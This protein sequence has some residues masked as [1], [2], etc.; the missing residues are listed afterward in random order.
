MSRKH[1]VGMSGGVD[2]TVAALCLLEQGHPVEGLFM[3]N[4]EEDEDGY[5]TT[6]QDFQDARK[7]CER[8]GITLH[9]VSFAREYRDAVFAHFLA[10]YAAGRTPN[11]DVLCNREIKF[12]ACLDYARRLGAEVFATGHYARIGSG[13]SLLRAKDRAKDQT[14]FLHAVS[15]ADFQSTVFPIGELQK[16]EVRE[17]ARRHGLAT[18]DKKDST[19]ICFIGERPFR[20]FLEQYLPAR[21]GIIEDL[22]GRRVGEHRG[23]MYYTLGQRSG[24]GIG[25]RKNADDAPWFVVGKLMEKNVLQVAQ[26]HEHPALFQSGLYANQLHWVRGQAPASQFRCTAKVRYRQVD[27]ACQVTL[28][29]SAAR[30]EFDAPVWAATP[31]QYA[32][33]YQG[34][35]CLGGGVIDSAGTA[36]SQK[37]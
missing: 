6:A 20:Q 31:G 35:E 27:V 16:S 5:C 33:F 28:D 2:S 14:Y 30:V 7:V 15:A 25:G 17:R 8:L 4:W 13:G 23:L 19:G 1:I 26:G 10:E 21:P 34:E 12:G 24:L 36:A 22:E 37:L 29:E 11:P 32:V 9:R 18:H 3:A